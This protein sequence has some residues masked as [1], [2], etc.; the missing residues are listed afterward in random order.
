MDHGGAASMGL[1]CALLQADDDRIYLFPAWPK[2]WDVE[3]KLHAPDQTTVEGVYRN[4]ELET[5]IVLPAEPAKD[6]VNILERA[7]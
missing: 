1:Q 4:G 6:V 7:R 5:L 3:F 2:D